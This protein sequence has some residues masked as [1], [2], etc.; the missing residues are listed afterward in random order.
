ML[1]DK[2]SEVMCF[3]LISPSLDCHPNTSGLVKLMIDFV[4]INFR[5]IN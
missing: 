5:L 3:F 4:N 1:K 2:L